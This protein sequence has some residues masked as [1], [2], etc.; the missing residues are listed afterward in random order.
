MTEAT[1]QKSNAALEADSSPFTDDEAAFQ[2]APWWADPSGQLLGAHVTHAG[3]IVPWADA[4]TLG[5]NWQDQ[6]QTINILGRYLVLLGV[7]AW[8]LVLKVM[9]VEGLSKN[10]ASSNRTWLLR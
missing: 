1:I 10:L 6:N 3:L 2:L 4:M 7:G 8:L 5:Y 9:F